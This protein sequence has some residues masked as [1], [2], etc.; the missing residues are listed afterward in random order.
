MLP[1]HNMNAAGMR[2]GRNGS[3]ISALMAS[4]QASWKRSRTTFT[5]S[6]AANIA[7]ARS[8]TE[9][10]AATRSAS[11]LVS[12][13][14]PAESQAEAPAASARIDAAIRERRSDIGTSRG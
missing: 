2:P 13:M 12:P 10:R 11:P 4:G 5:A 1:S 7:A 3:Q 14:V 9:G 8:E 6:T